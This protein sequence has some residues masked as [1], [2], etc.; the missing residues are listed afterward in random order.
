MTRLT[1]DQLLAEYSLT[2]DEFA[3]AQI[4]HMTACLASGAGAEVRD[5][6]EERAYELQ[7]NDIREV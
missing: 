6:L 2:G 5:A 3:P 4:Y 1:L 7:A